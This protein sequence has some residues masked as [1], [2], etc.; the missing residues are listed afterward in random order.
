M[1]VK[2]EK[3]GFLGVVYFDQRIHA[4]QGIRIC[5]R[6]VAWSSGQRRSLSLQGSRDRIP[7]FLFLLFVSNQKEEAFFS[8]EKT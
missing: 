7:V 6:G 4:V 1:G 2:N 8:Q 3:T 5:I